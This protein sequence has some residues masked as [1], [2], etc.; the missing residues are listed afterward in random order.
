MLNVVWVFGFFALSRSRAWKPLSSLAKISYFRW[1]ILLLVLYLCPWEA[2]VC[3]E[4]E[5]SKANETGTLHYQHIYELRV[6]CGLNQ[7]LLF[8]WN[9]DISSDTIYSIVQFL[10]IKH[11]VTYLLVWLMRDV[12]CIVLLSLLK[13]FFPIFQVQSRN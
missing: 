5:H 2:A 3:N 9:C 10:Q 11:L 1:F 4:L 13:D 12:D 7:F 6:D 8:F